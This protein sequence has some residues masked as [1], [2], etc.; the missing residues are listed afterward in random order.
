METKYVV[1]I[2]TSYNE[3]RNLITGSSLSTGSYYLITDFKTC[4]DQPDYDFAGNAISV[5]NYKVADIE[6]IIVHAT[7][8]NTISSVAYQ[9]KYPN[10]KIQYDWT[11]SAT[12]VTNGVA[13]GRI[14]ERIDEFNN[15]TDYDHRTVLF[16]RYDNYYYKENNIT[17]GTIELIENTGEVIGAET[18]FSNYNIG[19][20]IAIPN[21]NVTFF[22]I[23]SISGDTNMVVSG[24][25]IPAVSAGSSFYPAQKDGLTYKQNNISID[26]TEHPTFLFENETI[27]SNYIG[28]VAIFRNW[29]EH[30]FLL[31]NNVFGEDVIGNRIGNNFINNTFSRDVEH[32]VIGDYFENN[33]IYNDSDFANNK[34][35]N[36]FRNHLIICDGFYANVIGDG[37]N[38]NKFFNNN[39]IVDNQI[40]VRFN[41]N[42][43]YSDF[44]DNKIGNDFYNNVI[45][46]SFT[47]NS[48]GNQFNNNDTYQDFNDN[49]IGHDFNNNTI[50]P[51]FYKNEILNN[52]NDNIIGDSGNTSNFEFYEN[53][54]GNYF[55]TNTIRQNFQN[56]QIGNDFNSNTL[57]GNFYKNV[58]GNGFNNNPNIGY[59]FY[60]N[61]IGN[62]FNGNE[63]IGD[64]F[65]E[66]KIGENFEDNSI[67][68]LFNNNQ[69]G[70]TFENNTL[71]DTQFF[72]WD[73]TNIENLTGRTYNTFYNSLYGD[74]GNNVGNVI[75][76]KELIMRFLRNSGTTITSGDLVIGE[77]YEIT[78]YQGSDDFSN[79]A[80]IISGVTNTNGCIFIATGTTPTEWSSNSELTELTSYNEYHTVKFTQ[81]TQNNNGGGFSYERTK[82][83]PTVESTVYFTKTNYENVVDIIIPGR[84]EIK[85]GNGGAIYNDVL[86]NSWNQSVSPEGT[87]WNSIYTQPFNGSEFGYNTI[88][89]DFKGN[90]IRG[91]FA[92][93][94]IDSDV[95]GNQF[96]G[97]TYVNNIGVATYDNDFLGDVYGNNWVGPFYLNVIGDSF[98]SNSFGEGVYEN[99]IGTNFNANSFGHETNNNTIGE[100]FF[101]NNIKEYFYENT[102]GNGF[103]TNQIGSYFNS[104]II[105]D[106][107]GYGYAAPQGNKIGNNFYSNV[108]GEYF[109]NNTIPDN[110]ENNEIGNYFQWNVINTNISDTFFTLNYGNITGFT[111]TATGLSAVDDIYY[112]IEPDLS[113]SP[114]G[115]E[116]SFDVEVSGGAVIGVSGYTGGRLYE[117]GDTLTI[118]ANQIGGVVGGIYTFSSDAIGK[119]GTDNV[120]TG[121]TASG[122]GGENATFDITVT[123]SA[124]SD[125]IINARGAAYSVG[126][127]LTILGT[128]FGGPDN[129][130]ITADTVYSDDVVITV[131][132]VTPGSLFYD[133]YTKEVFERKLGDKRVSHYDENDVLNIDSIYLSSG[134]IPVYS[135]LL[136][137]PISDASFEFYCDGSYSNTGGTTS[138]TTNNV[139]DLVTLFNNNFRQFGYFFDNND[140]TLGL[141]TN[142]V[143]KQQYCPNGIYSLN[144]YSD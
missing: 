123:S 61:H 77:T 22:E 34:I 101:S 87:E 5:G 134:Y 71:G 79:V 111:Y 142:P 75:L 130:T 102:I 35:A 100:D 25:T 85:R 93:N 40:G 136:S 80:D 4:Y 112:N 56:N 89:G 116:A 3:L 109:Y 91:D 97:N 119:V 26:Y 135:D 73:N 10:D 29:N 92:G 107:F 115:V 76:G 94:K 33:T 36:N 82:V 54:I 59:D 86:E 138:T 125:I 140:G 133:H 51:D 72:N 55:N 144:V 103:Q 90:Y 118:S 88:F 99:T 2:I 30:D 127:T 8:S 11:Y 9:P 64:Y 32:N 20:Y 39:N 74:G 70:N 84:L 42:T 126:E 68:Y 48:I 16:K 13:Y 131:T 139:Q 18:I 37:I 106:N 27:I 83:Y 105:N 132:G 23:V 60:G 24:L 1:N 96:S 15:R 117:N 6:P 7:S 57:N 17:E 44:G 38:N 113:D 137:F 129:I 128:D 81:W 46:G 65:K 21:A 110:F 62:G 28:D 50:Y 143:L 69:I 108:V 122:T 12:E 104:N 63:L 43:I 120:Y 66:N 95:G 114:Q 45:D 121:V 67:S 31:P 141:Y 49:S 53:R 58:I 124:V 98:E 41:D 78:N 19:D 52:F 47:H 14:T